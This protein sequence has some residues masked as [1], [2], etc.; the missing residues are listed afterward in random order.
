M[1]GRERG[2]RECI[3]GSTV[4]VGVRGNAAYKKERQKAEVRYN[5]GR[6]IS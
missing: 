5:A 2:S 1:R 3:R 6:P 4:P